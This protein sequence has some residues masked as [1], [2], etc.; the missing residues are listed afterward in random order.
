MKITRYLLN[1]KRSSLSLG[2]ILEQRH[3]QQEKKQK[4]RHRRLT[5]L[6]SLLISIP[7]ITTLLGVFVLNLVS[8]AY[9]TTRLDI[10]KLDQ[11]GS[12]SSFIY[13]NS[14]RSLYEFYEEK[15]RY[16]VPLDNISKHM[17]HAVIAAEDK[18]FYEHEG[19][20]P[21][22]ILRS[23]Y[24]NISQNEVATGASTITQQVIK[25][26]LFS[27]QGLTQAAQSIDRKTDEMFLA[28]RL[29]EDFTKDQILEKYLNDIFLGNEA[30]GVEAAA[31]I[32]FNTSAQNLTIAQS[33]L[34][35]GIINQPSKNNPH[36]GAMITNNPVD[37]IPEK[38]IQDIQG[39]NKVPLYKARQAYVLNR[40]LEENYITTTQYQEAIAEE[41]QFP[42][43]QHNITYPHWVW[44]VENYV[45]Q[46]YGSQRLKTGGL[47]VY[48]TLNPALQDTAQ[49]MVRQHVDTYRYSRNMTNAAIVTIDP[50]NGHIL[51]MVGG[52]DYYDKAHDGEVNVI[53]SY[54]QPG[55]TMKPFI[56][57]AALEQGYP[58]N[59]RIVDNRTTFPGGYR[60]DNFDRRF[61]GT[62]TLRQA[63]ARSYNIPPVKL[64][65]FLGM[66]TGVNFA[67]KMGVNNYS[68]PWNYGLSFALGGY[69][70]RP[71]DLASAYGVFANE[72]VKIPPTPILY[73][74]D[75]QGNI[76]ED[77]RGEPEGQQVIDPAIAYIIADILS[78]NNARAPAFGSRNA[79]VYYRK[80]AAKTGTTNNMKDN[81]TVNFNPQLVNL[82]WAGNNNGDP[83]WNSLGSSGAA[84]LLRNY[85]HAAFQILNLPV[86]WYSRPE[87]VRYS[88]GDYYYDNGYYRGIRTIK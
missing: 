67:Q 11:L 32:Y 86:T 1:K 27:E 85:T 29:E 76:L 45:S 65:N 83:L 64:L 73:I 88:G 4:R 19:I 16:L 60:P 74:T 44:Y 75:D 31:Q 22:A 5:I 18:H 2:V 51:A 62:V 49:N 14:G 9:D 82:V 55:S 36:S 71:L 87:N 39:V 28:I 10:E 81:W 69:E 50:N 57:A 17:V 35:A 80:M 30:W 59:T 52:Y 6:S 41:F 38:F 70:V 12:R 15:R 25:H 72:G 13:D 33:A 3:R 79:L 42:S 43:I 20:D 34:I 46:K 47:R 23:G 78:D 84:P 56:Y 8:Y 24:I 68:D 77:N 7:I 54:R 61:H 37:N 21:E 26:Y 66:E 48:T 63:L 58:A 40:M 53:T